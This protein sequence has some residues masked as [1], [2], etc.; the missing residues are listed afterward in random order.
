M[1][2]ESRNVLLCRTTDLGHRMPSH[3]D[4]INT[5]VDA[6]LQQ[7][8]RCAV[9]AS[10]NIVGNCGDVFKVSLEPTGLTPNDS[11]LFL[12]CNRILRTGPSRLVVAP[13]WSRVHAQS[14]PNPRVVVKL[15]AVAILNERERHDIHRLLHKVDAGLSS[16]LTGTLLKSQ[17]SLVRRSPHAYLPRKVDRTTTRLPPWPNI[18]M[19]A[20]SPLDA[21]QELTMYAM[22][23]Y[24]M[25]C[26]REE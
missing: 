23:Q 7:S 26:D 14:M 13:G 20:R 19:A 22:S 10:L 8:T 9:K 1:V 3:V 15:E 5:T 12:D 18:N 25:K 16:C 17:R 24:Q 4:T 2:A 21:K 11:Q 6:D